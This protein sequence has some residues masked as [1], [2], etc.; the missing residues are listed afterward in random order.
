[1]RPAPEHADEFDFE[2]DALVEEDV[3]LDDDELDEEDWREFTYG[4]DDD[5]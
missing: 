3:E 1:M 4:L 2:E 5:Y